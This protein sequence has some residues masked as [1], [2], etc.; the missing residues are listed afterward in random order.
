MEEKNEPMLTEN[1]PI[2]RKNEP[3]LTE[4]EPINPKNEPIPKNAPRFL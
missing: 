1:E 4:N 3:M 2:C